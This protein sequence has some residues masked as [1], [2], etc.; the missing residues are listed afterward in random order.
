M[1]ASSQSTGV[2]GLGLRRRNVAWGVIAVAAFALGCGNG[3]ARVEGIVTLDDEPVRGGDGVRATVFFHPADG[4][5]AAV[6]LVDETGRYELKTGAETG[7]SPGEYAVTVTAT[8]K[9]MPRS[10]GGTPTGR[11]ISPPKYATPTTSGLRFTV[12]SGRNTID[13]GLVTTE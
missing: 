4:G 10:G 11:R 8:Q 2:T 1:R 3:L 9:V 12:E 5:S 7:V 6:G 13:L